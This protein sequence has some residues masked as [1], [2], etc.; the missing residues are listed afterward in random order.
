MNV[1]NEKGLDAIL[2][3]ENLR[4]AYLKV[5]ANRGAAGVDG[6]GTGELAAHI[7]E[8]WPGIEEKLRAGTYQPGLLKPVAIPKAGG[9]ERELSIPTTQD[10]LIQQ[11]IAQPL[12]EV[13]DPLFSKH[14]YGYRRGKSAH[15][16]V[17]KMKYFV[18][19]KGKRW[20]VDVDIHRFFD[21]V[22]HDILMHRTSREVK[23]KKVLRLIGSYLRTG[24]LV[25]NRKIR[26]TGKGIAQGGPLSPLLGNIYLNPLDWELEARGVSFARYA[27]DITLYVESR[28][29]GERLLAEIVEWIEQKLKL[30]VNRKKSGVRPPE[31]GNFLGYRMEQG[32]KLALSRKSVEAFKAEVRHLLDARRPWRWEELKRR[33]QDY[34]RGWSQYFGLTEWYEPENLSRWCRRHL[35]KLCW[36]RWHNWKGRRKALIRLGAKPYH[37]KAAHSSRGAWRMAKHG[38]L[39]TVLNNQRLRDWGFITPADLVGT[40]PC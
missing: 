9:G 5:K 30:R 17:R 31:E 40:T 3:P 37:V 4:A 24:K 11:A 32:G 7:R 39:Q 35:R 16:A 22:S 28:E 29:E 14:S 21:E 36:L 12:A 20:V 33:W 26:H 25:N 8:H 2:A 34:V 27:D 13:F 23:D 19:A 38:A 15:E 6:I 10:R 1:L 18:T